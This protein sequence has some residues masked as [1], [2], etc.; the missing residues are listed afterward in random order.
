MKKH[1]SAIL[2]TAL[3]TA[4]AMFTGCAASG[5]QFYDAFTYS[6]PTEHCSVIWVH[7]YEAAK[8]KLDNNLPKV[9]FLG[10]SSF[11]TSRTYNESAAE[12]D[13][14]KAGGDYIIVVADGYKGSSTSQFTVQSTQTYS[15]TS[16]TNYYTST[17]W[18]A[19]SA[20]TTGT[21]QAP[22]YQ[23]YN[24]TRHYYGYTYFVYKR[25]TDYIYRPRNSQ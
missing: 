18:Y 10:K 7:S 14:K 25:N 12:E 9:E 22:T 24:I 4:T 17:G 15:T 5:H 3:T 8:Y 6:A 11:T 23:T 16:S 20:M 21:Y 2:L 1:I 19:G 13:C